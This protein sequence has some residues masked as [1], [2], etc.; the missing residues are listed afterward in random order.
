MDLFPYNLR[1][2]CDRITEHFGYS[3]ENDDV[4]QMTKKAQALTVQRLAF[5][6]VCVLFL[7]IP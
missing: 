2:L 5:L 7:S 1:K 3:F 4:I 6:F